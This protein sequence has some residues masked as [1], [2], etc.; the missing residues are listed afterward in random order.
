MW[1]KVLTS[2]ENS[3][4]IKQNYQYN[5]KEENESNLNKS[6]FAWEILENRIT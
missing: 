1:I 5:D 4:S 6:A 2:E 3:N